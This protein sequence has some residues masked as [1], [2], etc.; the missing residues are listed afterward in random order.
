MNRD[1]ALLVWANAG[2]IEGQYDAETGEVRGAFQVAES[3]GL[4]KETGEHKMFVTG[5][6]V[7]LDKV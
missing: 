4:E 7:G 2:I 5:Y 1:E 3:L 6:L